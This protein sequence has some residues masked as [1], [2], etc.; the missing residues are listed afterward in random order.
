[1]VEITEE[2]R[3]KVDKAAKSVAGRDNL[4]EWEDLSQDIWVWLLENPNQYQKYTEMEDPYRY[5]TKIA[6]QQKY[7]QDS[8]LEH[9]SGNYTYNPPEVRGLLSEYLVDVTLERVS[10]HVDLVEG[11][12][13]LRSTN[14][15]YFKILV[16]KYVNGVDPANA[17]AA[18]R[19]TDKLTKLMNQV[20]RA[21]RYS[22][23]GIGTRRVVSNATATAWTD[24]ERG[25]RVS[26]KNDRDW[27]GV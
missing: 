4:V 26:S 16:D 15:S 2:F 27:M 9:F 3:E 14:A 17:S 12:L 5:L 22:H 1:M 13:M 8:S 19:A 18:T 21:A 25:Q 20:N 6:R 7:K 11:M 23:E 24:L 10:E